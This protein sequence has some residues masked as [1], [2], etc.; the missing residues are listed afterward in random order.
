MRRRRRKKKEVP[1]LSRC[2]HN[3]CGIWRN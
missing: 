3:S 2:A 1:R